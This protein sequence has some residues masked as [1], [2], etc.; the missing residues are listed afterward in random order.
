MTLS[1]ANWEWVVVEAIHYM[2]YWQFCNESIERSFVRTV[3]TNC[4]LPGAKQ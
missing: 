4:A 1:I 3:I 2:A